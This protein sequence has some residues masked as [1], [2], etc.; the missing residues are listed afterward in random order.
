MPIYLSFKRI[1]GVI[2]LMKLLYI[3]YIDFTENPKS[4]S[5][6]RPQKMYK[7]FLEHGVDVKL[8]E[9][10]QNKRKQRKE[11]VKEILH[12]LDSNKPDICYI[13]SPSGPIFNYIDLK[14]IKKVHKMGIPIGYF[15]RDAFWLFPEWM[16]LGKLKNNV[17]I[18]MN[19]ITLSVLKNNC[20]I[21]Y[22]PT[23][24]AAELFDF[25]YFKRVD[26]L[27]PAADIGNIKEDVVNELYKNCVYVGAVSETDGT[28][29][30]LKAF[31]YLND[32]TDL[33]ISLTIVCREQ[34]WEKINKSVD[35][36]NCK[37]LRVIHASGKELASIYSKS[38]VALFPRQS[39]KYID[40][41]MP[42][43][44]FEY[45]SFGKPVIA[46]KRIEPMKFIME[47]NCGLICND[48]YKSIAKT[49]ECFYRDEEL[50]IRLKENVKKTAK[51]NQWV[52]RAN[53]VM[54]DL[55]SL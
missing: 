10:Q 38:D 14:L 35:D 49:I 8:L 26:M 30:L 18:F 54:E 40:I 52:N 15:Y 46:T 12:W 1:T 3:T 2:I 25:A 47:N 44:L 50:Q 24:S 13:E 34:E 29:E 32:K 53:K 6:V 5:A 9:C 48:D 7:A 20:D 31:T 11:K 41:A 39:D 45:F 43:K 22:F 37:W 28:F 42:V 23:K 19:K 21:L 51:N 33:N 36:T 55:C 4:G 16:N 17:I 27:P